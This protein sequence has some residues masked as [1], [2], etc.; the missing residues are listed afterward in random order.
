MHAIGVPQRAR[1]DRRYATHG[2]PQRAFAL[3]LTAGVCLFAG[4]VLGQTGDVAQ[5]QDMLIWTTDYEGVIDGKAGQGTREAIE[6]FQVRLGNP[7]T[8]RLTAAELAELVRQGTEKKRRAGFRQ[9][10]DDR[11]G[12]SVGIPLGFAPDT[13]TTR[14]GKQWYGRT[15]GLAI[16]TL[17]FGD[18]SLRD[19]H[20]RLISINNRDVRYDRFVDGKWFAISAFENDAAVYVRANVI[21]L[22]NGRFELRG[23]SIWMSKDRPPGY[24]AIP[25]AMLSSYRTEGPRPGE[26]PVAG[27][28]PIGGT[29]IPVPPDLRP[30]LPPIPASGSAPPLG[31][32]FRGLG[33][34]CPPVLSFR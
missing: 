25:P 11:S 3:A 20:D 33:P 1:A 10:T 12:V 9:I 16:D 19:L 14:W 17:R 4:P 30:N 31:D 2:A 24:Q 8:G 27:G 22:P 28:P 6:K 18:V 13:K 34:G 32:C 5:Q 23:F 21:N 15:A 29:P 7:A 26:Q